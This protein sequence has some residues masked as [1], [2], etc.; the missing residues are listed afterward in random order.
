MKKISRENGIDQWHRE[1]AGVFSFGVERKL[2]ET[3]GDPPITMR[4]S[5]WLNRHA[6]AALLPNGL[7]N[8]HALLD[9]PTVQA[10]DGYTLP[11]LN[12][13]YTFRV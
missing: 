12:R 8:G 2:I 9:P 11:R 13:I 6:L 5:D 7:P 3:V 4:L 10:Q 1:R